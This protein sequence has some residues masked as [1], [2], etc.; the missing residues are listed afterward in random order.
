MQSAQQVQSV[1]WE[2]MQAPTPVLSLSISDVIIAIYLGGVLLMSVTLLK[3]MW[4]ISRLIRK[5]KRQK[6]E[7]F[8][9]VELPDTFPASSFFGYVFYNQQITD[10]QQLILEHEKVHIRQWHSIDVLAME[11]IVIIKWF[12]PLIYFFRNALKATHEFIADQYVIQQKTNRTTYAYLLIN[13]SQHKL[14]PLTNTFYSLTKER[15]KMML[16][17]PSNNW[18]IT[19]YALVLPL[20]FVLMSLFSFNLL[21]EYQPLKKG[22]EEIDNTFI[23]LGKKSILKINKP[24]AISKNKA[25]AN[26]TATYTIHWGEYTFNC[27]VN[28]NSSRRYCNCERK[29]IAKADLKAMNRS[30][31]KFL[32]DGKKVD[33][34]NVSISSLDGA[35]YCAKEELMI[36]SDQQQKYDKKA[37]IWN[38]FDEDDKGSVSFQTEE[39]ARVNFNFGINSKLANTTILPTQVVTTSRTFP[40]SRNEK[41]E[42]RSITLNQAVQMLDKGAYIQYYDKIYPVHEIKVH[43]FEIGESKDYALSNKED[44]QYLTSKI[45]EDHKLMMSLLYTGE[46]EDRQIN[47]LKL[48]NVTSMKDRQPKSFEWGDIKFNYT[49]S[50]LSLQKE[51][52]LGI[53][54]NHIILSPQK[55]EIKTMEGI[56]FIFRYRP[57]VSCS[58][59]G[60][61]E[62]MKKDPCFI[63]N[64]ALLQHGD[65]L[66]FDQ[67]KAPMQTGWLTIII[68]DN[69]QPSEDILIQETL[70]KEVQESPIRFEAN[71]QHLYI[72]NT[73]VEELVKGLTQSR[74]GTLKV[75]GKSL[76]RLDIFFHS[77]ETGLSKEEVYGRIFDALKRQYK[78]SIKTKYQEQM[79]WFLSEGNAE[80]LSQFTEEKIKPNLEYF[81][82]QVRAKGQEPVG[83][84]EYKWFADRYFDLEYGI[85]VTDLTEFSGRY[86]LPLKTKN[87]KSL[88]KQL[89]KDYGLVLKQQK[90]TI[91][92]TVVRFE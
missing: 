92:M 64:M 24:V 34:K 74:H 13:T 14:T 48:F 12:N 46:G 31:I 6:R 86:I 67:L 39:F 68:D 70:Q 72:Q 61:W 58:F 77:K 19:K 30:G 54:D 1:F 55:E 60:T 88:Q 20:F 66:Y 36:F 84:M 41:I 38:S 53:I 10:E 62:E 63:K 81:N 16:Q 87:L 49:N 28:T 59:K 76:P 15:L 33:F 32:K 26:S 89:K 9:Q 22:L 45:K 91:P 79:G 82:E 56:S 35:V 57:N 43:H 80:K 73:S 27:K 25:L 42:D 75:I 21:E 90:R 71:G 7:G 47:G 37:C 3:S 50:F 40:L 5:G 85:K 44:L 83:P 4:R 2:Q 51:H 17:Q 52:L 23:D 65:M 18:K 69:K 29:Y 11:L 78:V 8:T